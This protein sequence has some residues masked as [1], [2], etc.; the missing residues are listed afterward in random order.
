MVRKHEC[1]RTE[2]GHRLRVRFPKA[3]VWTEIKLGSGTFLYASY[4]K[5]IS[6]GF[7]KQLIWSYKVK[8]NC[9]TGSKVSDPY[10]P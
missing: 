3:V 1:S 9:A 5:K 7:P 8:D 2:I 4:L 6:L 10:S